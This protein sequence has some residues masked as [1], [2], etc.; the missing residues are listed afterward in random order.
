[1][2]S[3]ISSFSCTPKSYSIAPSIR[4]PLK[5]FYGS[6]RVKGIPLS[7]AATSIE[8]E[9]AFY[10]RD[11]ERAP[12]VVI[13][14]TLMFVSAS[15]H[16]VWLAGYCARSSASDCCTEPTFIALILEYRT[17]WKPSNKTRELTASIGYARF[18]SA[19]CTWTHN[20][21]CTRSW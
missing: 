5:T 2:Y 3:Y 20:Y 8:I 12:T 4:G 15:V 1:M 7:I 14:T 16:P 11:C 13:S 9:V 6:I 17:S 21:V 18:L 10:W 19:T